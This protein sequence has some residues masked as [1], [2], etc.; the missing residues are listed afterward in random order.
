MITLKGL[1]ETQLRIAQVPPKEIN[2]N[3]TYEVASRLLSY[4]LSK[5]TVRVVKK[6]FSRHNSVKL[7]SPEGSFSLSLAMYH[8]AL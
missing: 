1:L 3:R 5:M 2:Q 7:F 8:Y 4:F 6:C